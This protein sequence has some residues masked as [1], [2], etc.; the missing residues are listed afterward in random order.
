[1]TPACIELHGF[2]DASEYAYAAVLY[3]RTVGND[4][5]VVTRI[6]ASKTR[7]APTKKHQSQGLELLGA[8]ILA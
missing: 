5:K 8:L 4:D 6:I 2:N 7:V 1:M 3:L